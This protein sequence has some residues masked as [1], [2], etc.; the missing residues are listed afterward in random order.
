MNV[1]AEPHRTPD[2]HGVRRARPRFREPDSR[3]ARDPARDRAAARP[4]PGGAIRRLAPGARERRRRAVGDMGSSD[5][6]GD[7][8]PRRTSVAPSRRDLRRAGLRHARAARAGARAA[9]GDRRAA[10]RGARR[11]GRRSASSSSR[12]RSREQMSVLAEAEPSA[13]EAP[14]A[15]VVELATRLEEPVARR[16]AGADRELRAG[17]GS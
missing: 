12:A 16:R 17:A 14:E 11:A 1:A 3:R 9:A 5:A 4:D 10:R 15:T 13:A 7:G 2:R 8:L 6:V